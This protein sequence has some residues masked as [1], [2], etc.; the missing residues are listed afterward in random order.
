MS[1]LR[2]AGIEKT[3]FEACMGNHGRGYAA[4]GHGVGE[5]TLEDLTLGGIDIE[6]IGMEENDLGGNG[7]G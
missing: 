1:A 5:M 3:Q 7:H 6:G 2:I 4:V